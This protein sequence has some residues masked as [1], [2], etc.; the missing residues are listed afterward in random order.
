M[1]AVLPESSTCDN[2]D[3][4][5]RTDRAER[6][7]LMAERRAAERTRELVDLQL[8]RPE[9][10]GAYAPAEFAADAVRWAV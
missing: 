10:V 9:V 3:P 4:S 1:T 8:A 2:D 5:V 6:L 7:A